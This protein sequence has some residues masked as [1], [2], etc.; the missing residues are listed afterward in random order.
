MIDEYDDDEYF[1]RISECF[2][3]LSEHSFE[4]LYIMKRNESLQGCKRR[5]T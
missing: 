1:S 3:K 4:K 5:K 2:L